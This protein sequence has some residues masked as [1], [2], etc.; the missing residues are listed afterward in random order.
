MIR[1]KFGAVLVAWFIFALTMAAYMN[2][3]AFVMLFISLTII[4][5]YVIYQI[6]VGGLNSIIDIISPPRD[7]NAKNEP[8][9]PHDKP[10]DKPKEPKPE[11]YYVM[12]P[13]QLE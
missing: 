10:K 2:E 3:Y 5:L 7:R 12:R 8:E 1:L 6:V 11:V 4:T 9:K 13:S